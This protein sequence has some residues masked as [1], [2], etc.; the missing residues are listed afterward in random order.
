MTKN[1][2]ILKTLS[3]FSYILL[4]DKIYECKSRG[5][6]KHKTLSP[7][8]GDNVDFVIL[9]EKNLKGNIIKIN[10]RKNELYR[11]KM[12]NID[13]VVIITS[14]KEP[15]FNSF[16]LNKYLSLLE[17]KKIKP[18]LAFTKIDLLDKNDGLFEVLKLYKKIGYDIYFLNNKIKTSIDY[19][20]FEK[21][22]ENKISVFTGQT[23]AGKSTTLNHL[24]PNAFEKTQEI[25]KALGRGK[26]TTTKNEL[27]SFSGGYIGDTPGFSS[28]ELKEVSQYELSKSYLFFENNSSNCKFNDCLHIPNT[29]N[30]YILKAVEN[31]DFPRFI[32]DDYLKILDELVVAKRKEK[33]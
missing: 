2:V 31:N 24:L 15:V 13:Q 33:F 17:I 14:V 32:Y 27:F 18:I 3:E 23:G 26:H 7:I 21:I 8:T 16:T 10:P 6:L 29:P 20:N 12:A 25:S 9:D 19:E 5:I 1:G 11:P 22:L 30:C 28:F 4:E